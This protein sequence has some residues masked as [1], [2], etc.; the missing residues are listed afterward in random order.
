MTMDLATQAGLAERITE[1]V[2]SVAAAPA[3]LHAPLIEG[4]A[5]DYVKECL[6][7][8]WVST[9]GGFVDRFEAMLC[10]ATGA[11]HAIATVN[12]TAALH[13]ALVLAGV[14]RED[15]VIIP[16]LTFVATANAVTYVGAIPHFADSEMP[17]LGLDPARLAERL[18]AVA[19]R[20]GD[21]CFNRETGRRI[22]AV[23]CVHTFGHPV[24]L[25]PL[26]ALCRRHGIPLI[27]DA[28]ESLGSLYKG[29]HTGRDG[30][31]SVLSFNGNKIVT[32]GGG[33]AILTGDAGLAA[34]ARHLTTTAKLPHRW[35]FDFDRTG[36]NYRLPN[37]NAAL[38]CAQLECLDDFVARKRDLADRYR[39]A[40]AGIDEA[41]F[42]DQ[43][44]FAHSNYWLNVFLLDP[45]CAGARDAVL[46]RLNDAGLQSR[47]AWKPLHMLPMHADCPMMA[48]PVAEDLYA[49][50]INIPSGAALCG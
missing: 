49:R 7:T 46:G 9:A 10:Q 11:E 42:F 14:G 27:E 50:L 30:M 33:G 35:E 8:G 40:F 23:I 24:D 47:P 28:A 26:V 38:G 2:G 5:W 3:G 48:L 39:A 19:E 21:D 20:R 1:A 31:L 6:D 4:N 15:E 16:A 29:R 37:I 32:T 44:E 34:T 22:G 17:T 43:P 18:D 41:V 13:A 25:D 12:G 36:F 45:D